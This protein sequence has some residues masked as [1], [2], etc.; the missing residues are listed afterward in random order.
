MGLYNLSSNFKNLI[1]TKKF[2]LVIAIITK[3]IN[4]IKIK[5]GS[6]FMSRIKDMN[7]IDVIDKVDWGLYIDLFNKNYSFF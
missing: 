2:I 4:F 1:F 5:L 6:R 3:K 7:T